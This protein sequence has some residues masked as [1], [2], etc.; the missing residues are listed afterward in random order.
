MG[1]IV[2]NGV[3]TETDGSSTNS[4][5]GASQGMGNTASTMTA[6]F[7]ASNVA[8]LKELDIYFI[9]GQG[10]YVSGTHTV[11]KI[12][13]CVVNSAAMDF[14]LEGITTIN[15]SGFASTITD[16]GSLLQLVFRKVLIVLVTLYAIVLL[17]L[18]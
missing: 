12:E 2:G 16:E 6:D 9:M 11:Y 8:S 18:L 1:T 17:L 15:W 13:A 7:S 4:A 14:D 3:F 5:W 10:A